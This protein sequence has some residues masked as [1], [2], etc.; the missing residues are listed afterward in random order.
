MKELTV[1]SER[2]LIGPGIRKESHSHGPP[3]E[4]E[5]VSGSYQFLKH[6]L[7][8]IIVTLQCPLLDLARLE[9]K[10][11]ICFLA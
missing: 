11:K 6:A 2:H 4:N 1:L 5:S 7:S 3:I 8:R 10:V 9:A